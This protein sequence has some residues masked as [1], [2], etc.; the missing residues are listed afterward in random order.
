MILRSL[1]IT[2]IARASPRG[3]WVGDAAPGIAACG[4][5]GVGDIAG[6]GG[7]VLTSAL[8]VNMKAPGHSFCFVVKLNAT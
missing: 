6:R 7:V 1:P 8:R 2:E 5:V 4:R 3:I